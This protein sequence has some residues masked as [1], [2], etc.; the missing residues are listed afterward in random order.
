MMI[1]QERFSNSLEIPKTDLIFMVSSALI[2]SI[3][4][5]PE[6]LKGNNKAGRHQIRKRIFCCFGKLLRS[7]SKKRQKQKLDGASV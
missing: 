2:L 6:Q 3:L 1:R 5:A 4:R 7:G